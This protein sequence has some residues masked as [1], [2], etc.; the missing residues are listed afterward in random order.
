V[1]LAVGG[2]GLV[3][4]GLL[5]AASAQ[6]APSW[7][8]P[9]TVAPVRGIP[10]PEVGMDRGG[11][12]TIVYSAAPVATNPRR[13]GVFQTWRFPGS[14]FS[15]PRQVGSGVEPKVAVAPSGDTAIAWID[16]DRIELLRQAAP[17]APGASGQLTRSI[18]AGG[19]GAGELRLVLDGGGRATVVW[20]PR[21]SSQ[22]TAPVQLR[23][24]SVSAAGDVAPTQE[25][26]PPE[27]CPALSVAGNLAGDVAA[28]CGTSARQIHVRAPGQPE[29]QTET[30]QAD[31]IDRSGSHDPVLSSGPSR[32]TVDGAGLVTVT[33]NV[34]GRAAGVSGYRDRPRGGAFGPWRNLGN[35]SLTLL[36]QE[37]R[38]VA[39][40]ADGGGLRFA[41]RPAG[42]EFGPEQTAQVANLG[43]ATGG[44]LFEVAAPLGPLPIL[45]GSQGFDGVGVPALTGFALG[46][47]GVA[48]SFGR[49]GLPGGAVDV[50]GNVAA[51]ESGIAV[52][53][54]EQRCG[55]GTA[56]MAMALDERRGTTEPPC[57]DRLAP[58]ALVRPARVGLSGRTL[59]FRAG[60][61]ESCRMVVRIRVLQAGRSR[62]LATRKTPRPVRLAASRYRSFKLRLRASDATR[63]RAALAARKRVSVRFAL[64]VRDDFENGA[65]RRLAVRLR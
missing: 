56:V 28:L 32:V 61:D 51:S 37:S 10:D 50:P 6:A 18:D 22:S 27:A 60:C 30:F 47:A 29:F 8:S 65:V 48:T 58:K 64:S 54:W 23:A 12:A 36:G 11:K 49:L 45:V 39:A 20:T 25:L 26:G 16:G 19:N 42:G 53:T 21:V 24:A 2:A 34:S 3:A 15:A 40:W 9:V 43:G 17:G 52:A 62:P 35:G 31:P 46:P 63:V 59:S 14:T 13:P 1:A 4:S 55:D 33:T 41:V 44:V 5:S 38:T 57:Q 7:T